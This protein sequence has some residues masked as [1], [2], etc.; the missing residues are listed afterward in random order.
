MLGFLAPFRAGRS[1]ETFAPPKVSNTSKGGLRRGKGGRIAFLLPH[2][3]LLKN[4]PPFESKKLKL[5]LLGKKTVGF[6]SQPLHPKEVDSLR[7]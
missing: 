2:F 6:L 3:P 4:P 1:S 7:E 5:F